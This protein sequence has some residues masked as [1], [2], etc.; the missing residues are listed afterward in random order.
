M[1]LSIIALTHREVNNILENS[2]ILIYISRIHYTLIDEDMGK[3]FIRFT[4]IFKPNLTKLNANNF[5]EPQPL[6]VQL[7]EMGRLFEYLFDHVLLSLL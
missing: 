7:L 1:I 4:H 5:G 6:L 3:T 2:D